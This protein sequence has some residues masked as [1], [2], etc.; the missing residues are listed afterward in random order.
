[1]VLLTTIFIAIKAYQNHFYPTNCYHFIC[2]IPTFT[3]TV[4]VRGTKKKKWRKKEIIVENK[5]ETGRKA[6]I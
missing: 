5:L 1:M 6:G 3:N 4:Y 2:Y